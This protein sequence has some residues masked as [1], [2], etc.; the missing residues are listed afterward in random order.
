MRDAQ[1]I[2]FGIC[3]SNKFIDQLGLVPG[4]R[5]AHWSSN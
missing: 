1:A 4:C 3:P 5:Y 2:F